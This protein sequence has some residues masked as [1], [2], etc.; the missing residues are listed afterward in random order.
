M[1]AID[2]MVMLLSLTASIGSIDPGPDE[3]RLA[4]AKVYKAARLRLFVRSTRSGHHDSAGML[5][6]ALPNY[7]DKAA[8]IA[9]SF[10]Q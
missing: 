4:I 8:R 7:D 3:R 2:W 1:E 5:F 10:L 9:S 6:G